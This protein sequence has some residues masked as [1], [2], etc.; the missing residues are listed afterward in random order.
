MVEEVTLCRAWGIRQECLVGD[1]PKR[2]SLGTQVRLPREAGFSP[3]MEYIFL[4]VA[5]GQQWGAGAQ[6]WFLP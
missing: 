5:L 4:G 1:S 2:K 3:E 6:A